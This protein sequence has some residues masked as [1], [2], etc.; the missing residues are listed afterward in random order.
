[1]SP[2]VL[3]FLPAF[4]VLVSGQVCHP[5]LC[6]MSWCW[7]SCWVRAHLQL[8]SKGNPDPRAKPTLLCI[9]VHVFFSCC[10]LRGSCWFGWNMWHCKHT[11]TAAKLHQLEKIEPHPYI[12]TSTHPH[13]E[14]L[15]LFLLFMLIFLT[16]A[17]ILSFQIC[18]CV[19]IPAS[20]HV[21][22]ATS[23]WGFFFQKF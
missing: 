4:L 13:V 21:F 2:R 11:E 6:L 10:L 3:S 7:F 17:E 19:H 14:A 18:F 15:S 12:H 9:Q 22:E 1:M 5:W 16:L 20:D 8:P 23:C